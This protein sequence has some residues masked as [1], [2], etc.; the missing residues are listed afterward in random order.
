MGFCGV[1]TGEVNVMVHL[2]GSSLSLALLW[3]C[4]RKG[5]L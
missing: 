3:G 2:G 4:Y 1:V 5:V